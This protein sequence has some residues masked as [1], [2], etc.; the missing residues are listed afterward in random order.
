MFAPFRHALVLATTMSLLQRCICRMRGRSMQP[1]P[2]AGSW[3]DVW[4]AIVTCDIL[5]WQARRWPCARRWLRPCSRERRHKEGKSVRPLHDSPRCCALGAEPAR[6]PSTQRDQVCQHRKTTL[7]QSLPRL[8]HADLPR[9]RCSVSTARRH[10]RLAPSAWPA[11]MA[12]ILS[13]ACAPQAGLRN[14][15]A[16]HVDETR[17]H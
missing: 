3:S 11:T 5:P 4:N 13:A 14:T 12:I 1:L 15:D 8:A 9:M 17:R 6:S 16:A 7:N 10:T 2:E